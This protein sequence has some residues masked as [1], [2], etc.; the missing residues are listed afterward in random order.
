MDTIA[1]MQEAGKYKETADAYRTEAVQTKC[2]S[3]LGEDPTTQSLWVSG[4]LT[5]QMLREEEAFTACER[6]IL[7]DFLGP[8]SSRKGLYDAHDI[9]LVFVDRDIADVQTARLPLDS[10]ESNFVGRSLTVAGYGMRYDPK[11]HRNVAAGVQSSGTL[12]FNETSLF[13]M[14]ASGGDGRVLCLGDSGGGL[15][16]IE[17][18]GSFVVVGVGA[19]AEV[20]PYSGRCTAPSI[21]TRVA[22]YVAWIEDTLRGHL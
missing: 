3:L 13:E 20:Q 8:W 16:D 18:D 9:A 12:F 5:P 1:A 17:A 2:G 14:E 19:R 7:L 4:K 11:T 6:S 22:P 15:F 10:Y 21:A